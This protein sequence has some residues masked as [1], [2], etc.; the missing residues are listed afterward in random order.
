MY[1]GY[2]ASE[3]GT[4]AYVYHETWPVVIN[5]LNQR[6]FTTNVLQEAH[7]SATRTLQRLEKDKLGFETRISKAT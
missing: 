4:N 7:E 3:M 5:G 1:E 6:F 2:S